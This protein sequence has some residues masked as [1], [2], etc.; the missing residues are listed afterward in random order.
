MHDPEQIYQQKIDAEVRIE[1]RDW[2]P[3]AY[4]KTLVRQISQHAHSEIV[5]M[6][7]EGNWISR[8]P[9]LKRKAILIAK[10]QDEAGHGLYL[11][12]ATE[13]LGTSREETIN[14]LHS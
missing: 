3:D 1:P 6:L 12:S 11:Y 13:T 4:R 8:A 10:V 7:P 2:M 9:S 14:D 5:G